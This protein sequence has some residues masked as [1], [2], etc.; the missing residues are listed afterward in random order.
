MRILG[1]H[2]GREKLLSFS[3]FCTLIRRAAQEAHPAAKF[4]PAANGFTIVLDGRV[5]TCNLRGLYAAY[6][7]EPQKRDA[8]IMEFLDSLE[9]EAPAGTWYDTQAMLRPSL[10]SREFLADAQRSLQRQKVPDS[11]PAVHFLGELYV[12]VMAEHRSRIWAV[13]QNLLDGWGVTVEQALEQAMSNMS[14]MAFPNIVSVMHGGPLNQEAGFVFEGNYLTSSWLLFER[15]R[16][17]VGQRL[18]SNFVIA[19]PNRSRLIVVRDDMPS[20]IASVQQANRNFHL[21][22]YPLTNQLYHVDIRATGGIVSVYQPHGEGERLSPDSPFAGAVWQTPSLPSIS[23]EAQ[24]LL[25]PTP[26]NP[27]E[28]FSE[29]TEESV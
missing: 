15:F 24:G 2:I 16:N 13:T 7:K 4:A 20:L 12:I 1:L 26:M 28:S 3:D 25:Q 14:I 5:Q 9:T 27:W 17:Y 11:L 18:Q 23:Q 22:P 21:Q 8:L 6:C 10:R 29:P 19:V